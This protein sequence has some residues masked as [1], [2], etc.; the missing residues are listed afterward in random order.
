MICRYFPNNFQEL[1]DHYASARRNE[2]IKSSWG[3][4]TRRR[5]AGGWVAVGATNREDGS[6]CF[7]HHPTAA[8]AAALLSQHCE[9]LAAYEVVHS[10]SKFTLVTISIVGIDSFYDRVYVPSVPNYLSCRRY[11]DSSA[12]AQ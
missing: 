3:S 4:K 9:I 12:G 5:R 2:T 7:T 11:V 10:K 1:D 8:A 6:A